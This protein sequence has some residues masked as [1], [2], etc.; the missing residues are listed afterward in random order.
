MYVCCV[1][2]SYFTAESVSIIYEQSVF[3]TMHVGKW[4]HQRKQSGHQ[5][6]KK[7]LGVIEH[8]EKQFQKNFVLGWVQV[9]N[10]FQNV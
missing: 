4:Y 9:Q 2:S 6:N 8:A 7:V 10:N 5:K 3:W 1:I